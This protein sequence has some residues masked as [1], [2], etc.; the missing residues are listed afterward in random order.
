[1]IVH[2]L[3]QH[4]STLETSVFPLAAMAASNSLAAIGASIFYRTRSHFWLAADCGVAD[5]CSRMLLCFLAFAFLLLAAH[6]MH[7]HIVD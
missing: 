4:E 7:V 2:R 1:M 6:T 5:Q 3:Q